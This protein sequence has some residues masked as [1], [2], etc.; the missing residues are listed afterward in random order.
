MK[1]SL[2]FLYSTLCIA[3][4]TPF[5]STFAQ[6]DSVRITHTQETGTLE[7]QR[8][9]DR[10]DYVF[11][12]K[13]PTKWMLKGYI[14]ATPLP[15][16]S[17]RGPSNEI[18][19]G[20]PQNVSYS[21]GYEQKIGKAFSID[22]NLTGGYSG[23]LFWNY[24]FASA[25]FRW[26]YDMKKRIQKDIQVSNLTGNYLSL[27]YGQSL[28]Q[29]SFRPLTTFFEIPFILNQATSWYRAGNTFAL[30]IGTQRRF[31]RRGFIDFSLNTGYV[32]YN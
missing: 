20:L 31:M 4:V 10:Y 19:S 6:G 21:F 23:E 3:W 1:K 18:S 17:L 9:I 25:E 8:F 28:P 13:E 16:L 11:M 14:S 27:K 22:L 15:N 24:H 30:K 32:N 29:P 5:H 7:N 2:L 12:T 26:F